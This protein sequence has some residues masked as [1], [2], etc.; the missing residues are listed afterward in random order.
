MS[1]KSV[2][3]AVREA[4]RETSA[5]GQTVSGAEVDA[6]IAEAKKG[7]VTVGEKQVLVDM[8]EGTKPS[9]VQLSAEGKAKLETYLELNK[10]RVTDL[11]LLEKPG[12][13]LS[14]KTFFLKPGDSLVFRA[15]VNQVSGVYGFELKPPDAF[16]VKSTL[17]KGPNAAGDKSIYEYTFTLK[18]G[19]ATGSQAT[20]HSQAPFQSRND[21]Q[22]AFDF[23]LQVD[24]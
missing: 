5:Q 14:G 19:A 2:Q 1:I 18:P 21:P 6:I 10:G 23:T 16:E 4:M 3:K 8:L 12:S 9:K 7:P 13:S 11:G 15:S 22:F 17:I 24:A 20:A